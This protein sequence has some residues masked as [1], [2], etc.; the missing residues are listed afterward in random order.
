MKENGVWTGGKQ[1]I[2]KLNQE[3]FFAHCAIGEHCPLAC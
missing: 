1:K 3:L 2:R